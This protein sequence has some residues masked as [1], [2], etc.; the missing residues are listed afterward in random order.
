MDT[1]IDQLNAK[2]KAK[3]LAQNPDVYLKVNS[4]N[5]HLLS[6]SSEPISSIGINRFCTLSHSVK[7]ITVTLLNQKQVFTTIGTNVVT[8]SDLKDQL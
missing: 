5:D 3:Y 2:I 6:N 4:G 7:F 8:S 1:P